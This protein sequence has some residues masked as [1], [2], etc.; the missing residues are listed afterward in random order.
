MKISFSWKS[1]LYTAFIHFFKQIHI[2]CYVSPCGRTQRYI[3]STLEEFK[4][5][6]NKEK[7]PK[8]K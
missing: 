1:K 5:Y 2:Q 7:Y 4:V 3:L 6:Q 8:A